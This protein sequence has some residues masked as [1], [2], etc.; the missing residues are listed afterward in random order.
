MAIKGASDT[1]QILF[2]AKM[3]AKDVLKKTKELDTQLQKAQDNVDRQSKKIAERAEK[4]HKAQSQRRLRSL[5]VSKKVI[6]EDKKRISLLKTQLSIYDKINK[7]RLVQ[8]PL[9]KAAKFANTEARA[10]DYLHGTYNKL[11]ADR[12]AN[13]RKSKELMAALNGE[14]KATNKLA[15]SKTKA[16]M[17]TGTGNS[18]VGAG[19]RPG[20][21]DTM[22]GEM[23]GENVG[24]LFGHK[25]ATTVQYAAAGAGI[26]AVAQAAR[27]GVEAVVDFDTAVRTMSAVLGESLV[28]SK[29]LG[30]ELNDLGSKFGGNQKAIYDIALALG[31]A[32]I[33]TENLTEATEVAIKMALLTG[34]TFEESS[35]AIISYQQV[36]GKDGMGNVIYSVEE[37]G[38]KLAYVANVSRLSTQDIGTFSNYALAAAKSAGLTVDAVGAMAASF[39][40]AGVNASTIGTQMRS[41]TRIFASQSKGVQNLF[42][43]MGIVQK[44]LMRDLQSGPEASNKAISDFSNRLSKLSDEDFVNFTSGLNKLEA[45]VLALL[46]NESENFNKFLNKSIDGVKGQLDETSVIV[47]SFATSWEGTMNKLKDV[48]VD[49]FSNT[50]TSL[51]EFFSR[52]AIGF[53]SLTNKVS[54]SNEEYKKYADLAFKR[55]ELME[56]AAKLESEASYEERANIEAR[57]HVLNKEFGIKEKLKKATE[58]VNRY[59]QVAIEVSKLKLNLIKAEKAENKELTKTI[60][61]NIVKAENELTT[62]AK[63]AA[64]RET[65][66]QK[67]VSVNKKLKEQEDI[68]DSLS[69]KGGFGSK[70]TITRAKKRILLLKAE[71]LVLKKLNIEKSKKT[72]SKQ[73]APVDIAALSKAISLSAQAH[74]DMRGAQEQLNIAAQQQIEHQQ[75]SIKLA[76]AYN[77]L[78][79]EKVAILTRIAEKS[80][81]QEETLNAIA[82]LQML[83]VGASKK[84]EDTINAIITK[85]QTQLGIQTSISKSQLSVN[86]ENSRRFAEEVKQYKALAEITKAEQDARLGKISQIELMNVKLKQ[87][88]KLLLQIARKD[89]SSG[90]TDQI[91]P[92]QQ[93]SQAQVVAA[94][95]QKMQADQDVKRQAQRVQLDQEYL[96]TREELA[97]SSTA[98]IF[99]YEQEQH[100]AFSEWRVLY[101]GK[102]EKDSAEIKTSIYYEEYLRKR[103]LL[104]KKATE[105]EITREE[106]AEYIKAQNA[107]LAKKANDAH[108]QE[109][110]SPMSQAFDAAESGDA[111]RRDAADKQATYELAMADQN[112]IDQIALLDQ[113][114]ATKEDYARAAAD[115]MVAIN[116]AEEDQKRAYTISSSIQA[117][118]Q[119][120][121]VAGSLAGT[122]DNLQKAGI[123]KSKKAH[124]AMQAM[125]IVATVAETYSSATKAFSSMASIPYVGP[126]L[127]AAA[128]A[129]AIAA[130]MANV[131]Q[132]KAQTFHTGGTVGPNGQKLRSDEIPAVLQTGER[133][134]SRQEVAQTQQAPVQ[135]ETVII[136][137]IDPAVI[138][139]YMTSRSGRKVINNVVNA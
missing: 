124:K 49:L 93:A 104:H 134:L 59:S 119:T 60:S 51:K 7:N 15:K 23:D 2:S 18:Q 65:G 71:L 47:A 127:G 74:N 43:D 125:Q 25:V 86:K 17:G 73:A 92:E 103:D 20:F 54:L 122:M 85:L 68:V 3:D 139:S 57:I 55:L 13:T 40:N 101:D 100:F 89:V 97:Y 84:Y 6:I 5:E 70:I 131:A 138:E 72:T 126:A 12:V 136:N 62:I 115:R 132:I 82:Q 120:A 21:V 9:A 105:G 118:D 109:Y 135:N 107:L 8:P 113:F 45:N 50:A 137:S 87:Q 96:A 14:T 99:G 95:I 110:S 29:K 48:S 34:D 1:I 79:D 121:A 19:K 22:R 91:T 26:Y 75:H 39:S 30:Q 83:S 33:A 108:K 24:S 106:E 31:R 53:E 36:F 129:A 130:G 44:S 88:K 102:V 58:G 35:K 81:T 16:T 61:E 28:T 78:D 94:K 52:A 117:A 64:L 114:N 10:N 111:S 80:K 77:N 116:K 133:V 46:R 66:K 128:A 37:L 38:D 98:K 11:E 4:T 56:L 41:L 67:I 27:S 69:K 90:G 123:L 63:A 76:I 42:S 32:G 112:Y